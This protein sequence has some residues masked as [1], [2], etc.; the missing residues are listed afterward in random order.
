MGN[1]PSNAL[2][3]L[4]TEVEPAAEARLVDV[5]SFSLNTKCRLAAPSFATIAAQRS[6]FPFL[7]RRMSPR[8]TLSTKCLQGSRNLFRGSP[9]LHNSFFRATRLYGDNDM[10]GIRSYLDDGKRGDYEFETYAQVGA[11]VTKIANA[12]HKLEIG[13]NAS[14]GILS[15]NRPEWIKTLLGLLKAGAICVPLYDTLGAKA[16]SFILNDADVSIT[17]TTA[18]RLDKV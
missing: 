9:R 3:H 2:S 18:D 10:L 8:S 6:S 5:G 15:I 14:V 17:F 4:G 16:V 13:S 12:L 1:A 7:L 11:Q